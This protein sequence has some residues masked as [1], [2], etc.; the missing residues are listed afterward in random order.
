M[1][2]TTVQ[3]MYRIL[4]IFCTPEVATFAHSTSAVPQ[5]IAP[6][7]GTSNQ[8]SRRGNSNMNKF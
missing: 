1:R 7:T 4:Y 8:G 2:Y 5:I 3:Q 6:N